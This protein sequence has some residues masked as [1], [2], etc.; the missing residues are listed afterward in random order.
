MSEMEG[1]REE[2]EER[3]EESVRG[4]EGRKV[5]EMGD[6]GGSTSKGGTEEQHQ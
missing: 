1:S 5:K 4:S 3:K 6:G 2:A